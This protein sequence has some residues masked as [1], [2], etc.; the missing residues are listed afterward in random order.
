MVTPPFPSRPAKTALLVEDEQSTLR[1]YQA[2]LKGLQEFT[3]LS[4][5]NGQEALELLKGQAVDVVVTDLNMP[6]LD[7]YGL[8]AALAQRYPSLPIIVITSVADASLQ[9][10]ALDLGAL[11]VIPKPPR[12]STLMEAIRTAGGLSAPGLV[13]GVGI[14]SLLQLMNWER[15]TATFTVRGPEATGYLY[16]KDGELIH[17]ALGAEEGLVAAYQLLSWEGAQ[18]EF[19]YTCRVQATIDLP[20]AEILMNLALF[21]D[22]KVKK[23]LPPDPFYDDKW[24]R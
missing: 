20:L 10:Q 17:A 3:L 22:M 1:F 9:N 13:R 18:V 12:L 5:R 23:I 7:G 16:V 24:T 21:R 11:Q 2:G 14:G 4:A 15:R 8:I 6:V 19:V